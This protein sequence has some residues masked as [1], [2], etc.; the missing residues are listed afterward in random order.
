MLL[1][2][3]SVFSQYYYYS[4]IFCINSCSFYYLYLMFYLCF[5]YL[6]SSLFHVY[7]SVYSVLIHLE[8]SS[9]CFFNVVCYIF[10]YLSSKFSSL[11]IWYMHVIYIWSNLSR[12]LA[13]ISILNHKAVI[14][15]QH[16]LLQ[17]F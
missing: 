13:P 16:S 1:F 15:F 10:L 4:S 5:F 8:Y 11:L 6:F 2:L 14:V 3:Y 7:F 9:C 17:Y 12:V